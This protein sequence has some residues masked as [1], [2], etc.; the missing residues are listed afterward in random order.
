MA[1][2]VRFWWRDRVVTVDDVPVGTSVLEWL[3]DRPGA[4]GTKEG[5][6]EGDCGAC[7]V[8]VG[9]RDTADG[10]VDRLVLH[11]ADA[12]LL[13]VPM[14]HGRALFTVEDLATAD[15]L[16]PVQQAM[17]DHHGSQC[18]FCTPGIVMSLW[19]AYE[20]QPAGR[21]PDRTELA[22]RLAG[23]LCRCTGYRSVLDA[24]EAACAVP[25]QGGDLVARAL[26]GLAATEDGA[27]LHYRHGGS[28][29]LA[30]TSAA[31]VVE[32]LAAH[33]GAQLL[34]GGTDLVLDARL[35]GRP[36]PSL[37]W[38]GRVPELLEVSRDS[39]HLRIGAAVPLEQAWAALADASPRLREWW[40]R[41][42]GPAI[43]S[44]GTLA[45]NVANGSPIADGTPV[46][47]AVDA[48]VVVAGPDG[49]RRIP[50]ERFHVDRRRTVLREGELLQRIDVPLAA[51]ARD[52]RAYK[53]S[54][55]FDS[56]IST[57]SA[58]VALDL[59]DG[60]VRDVRIVLGGMAAVV[61]RA[62]TAESVLRGRPWTLD[63]VREAADAL[64][65]DVSPISDHRASA[66]YRLR[67]ARG[68]LERW[69]LQTRPED[70][71]GVEATEV[72]A[73]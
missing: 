30:P 17:V 38:T 41:F 21:A 49:G 53:V 73:L 24:A 35:A 61:R 10:G 8:V 65:A 23:N 36:L 4:T 19:A 68:L 50:L 55:R 62:T 52:V 60:V 32:A 43:R 14:L 7:T 13:L 34:G 6:N 31:G 70:P 44:V 20:S 58:V 1:E 63:A 66:D 9:T 15:G 11:P 47:L 27:P 57:V 64:A 37:V 46:L 69:W 18:G 40:H 25:R 48:E 2:T 12:C 33:P 22:E 51:L 72:W 56:D 3:R 45:G 26:A 5:C 54:R 67:A 16:H 59:D 29:F 39:S 71:V 28:D 42:A